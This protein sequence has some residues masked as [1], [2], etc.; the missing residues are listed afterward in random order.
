MLRR[1]LVRILSAYIRATP[2]VSPYADDDWS[3]L[4]DGEMLRR[5]VSG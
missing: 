1:I 5:V 2:P 3:H 4:S